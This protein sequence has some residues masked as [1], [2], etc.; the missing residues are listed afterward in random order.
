MA[1]TLSAAPRLSNAA[2]YPGAR[3]EWVLTLNPD[4]EAEHYSQIDERTDYTFKAYSVAAGMI[5]PRGER[6]IVIGN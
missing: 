1:Q 6:T 3:W 5:K 4:Q 2:S